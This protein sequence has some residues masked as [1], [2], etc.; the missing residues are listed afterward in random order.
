[1]F[2]KVTTDT[3]QL[4]SIIN[5]DK[6]LDIVN[7]QFLKRLNEYVHEC[8]QK[9]RI[10]DKP[11]TD[12]ERQYNKITVL[13][14]Q[15]DIASKKELEAVENELS[16]KYLVV[17]YKKI[18]TEVTGLEDSEDGDFNAGRLWKLKKKLSPKVSEPPTAMKD[19]NGKLITSSED[20]KAEAVKHYKNVFKD[21]DITSN[22][23]DFQATR[24][25]LCLDRLDSASQVKSPEWSIENVT[26]V[27]KEL[28][29]GK[30]K[31]PYELPNE[32]FKPSVA[33]EDLILAVVKLMNRIKI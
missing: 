31:D 16:T 25:K 15:T 22:L 4:S 7:K 23:K 33:G 27:L 32:L 20:I 24:E 6:P 1:M 19:T 2:K 9:I 14:T 3:K 13:R 26:C 30:S 18:M 29:T 17:M 10:V 21:R 11:N 12:L 5:K 8:F 28:K